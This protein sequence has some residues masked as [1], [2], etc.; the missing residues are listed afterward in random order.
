VK[1]V[2]RAA[3]VVVVVVLL[4]ALAAEAVLDRPWDIE[5]Y[6]V[7][8]DSTLVLTT[9]SGWLDWTRVT[10]VSETPTSV[11]IAMKSLRLPLPG[12]GGPATDFTVQLAS[13]L[14][15]RTVIDASTGQDVFQRPN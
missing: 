5:T 11:T 7:V 2:V 15:N 12:T 3:A 10:S 6:R 8:D 1:P 4:V 9:S 14:D 13:P